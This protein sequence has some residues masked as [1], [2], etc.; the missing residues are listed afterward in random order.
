M[1]R[2]SVQS[3]PWH[4]ISF[5]YLWTGVHVFPESENLWYDSISD[6]LIRNVLTNNHAPFLLFY[7]EKRIF[8]RFL[9]II[10]FSNTLYSIGAFMTGESLY[11][12]LDFKITYYKSFG[13]QQTEC[14]PL[15]TVK[16]SLQFVTENLVITWTSCRIISRLQGILINS[17]F[18]TILSVNSREI[19]IS[20]IN[21][22]KT[23]IKSM[24]KPFYLNES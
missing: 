15:S 1:P 8:S 5:C 17:G 6:R 21:D 19:N 12:W 20:H 24:N 4:S 2:N 23:L 18:A 16:C 13:C 9:C 10:Y 14:W 11:Y 22:S 7:Y 3:R